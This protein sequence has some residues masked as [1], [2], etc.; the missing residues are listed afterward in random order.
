[1]TPSMRLLVLSDLWPPFPGGAERLMFNLTRDLLRRGVDATVL[2]GYGP[3]QQFDGPPLIVREDI[4][5][6]DRRDEGAKVVVQTLADVDPDALLVHHLYAREF[7]PEIVASGLPFVQVLLN[8]D[9]IPEANLAV[10]ISRWVW[11]RG[12]PKDGDL[13][14]TPPAFPDV[15]SDTHGDAIGFIKPIEHK[16]V[17]LFYRIAERLPHRRFVVLRGEWQTLEDIRERPNVTFLEPVDDMRD[18]YRQVRAVL[19]PSR[20]EDAGTVAQEAT[21]NGIP[22]ISSN[23]DG[24]VETNDGG[25]QLDRDDLD[26]WVHWIERLDDPAFVD[27]LVRAQRSGLAR[28]DHAGK[29]DQF[30]ERV[31]SLVP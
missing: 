15:V 17:D 5:V 21:L 23:V 12:E 14:I 10:C 4:G 19:V 27:A 6:F 3:A 28:Q 16:G 7:T 9:R 1:M 18:F 24:L 29:L 11:E 22:C 25:L 8:G 13:V 31:L 20:S 30:A 26:A 2:T